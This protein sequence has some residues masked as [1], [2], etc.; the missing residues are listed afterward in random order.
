MKGTALIIAFV[1]MGV[2][3]LL[4]VYF[5][6]FTLTESR[7]AKSQ[8]IG[9]QTYYLAEAGINK[10]IWKLKNE[11]P[12]KTC[13]VTS[14]EAY[15][16]DCSNWSASTI[17]NTDFLIPNS[18]T[19]VAIQ[20][21]ECAKGLITATS[22]IDLGGGK[23]SQ[24]VVKTTVYKA[25]ASPVNESLY[26][27]TPSGNTR[28]KNTTL[29]V[30]S[31]N[32]F[33]NNNLYIQ[34]SSDVTVEGK[35]L[36]VLLIGV[37]QGSSLTGPAQCAKNVC[38]TTSSCECDDKTIFDQWCEPG[39]CPPLEQDMPGIDFDSNATSSYLNQAKAND[40]SAIRTDGKTNCFFTQSEF[41]D[42]LWNDLINNQ[43]TNFSGVIY[44]DPDINLRG[45]VRVSATGT[46]VAGRNIK[47]GYYRKW[48]RGG[49]TKEGVSRI[50]ITDPGQ[51]IPS[52]LLAK[53]KIN[54]A[55]YF[56]IDPA[57]ET[58]DDLLIQGLIYSQEETTISGIPTIP[59]I[60][61]KS[62]KIEGGIVARKLD[63]DGNEETINIY[64]DIDRIKEGIWGG[65]TP[66]PG[67]PIEYSPI[68]TIEHWE[69]EY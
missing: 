42:L 68:I 52:G 50:R 11:D 14:S 41:E 35:A 54:I 20:N 55:S 22:T 13:F 8:T 51:D 19:S 23:F 5:L 67:E 39:K 27:G 53:S 40:C 69:E 47:V 43:V 28:I 12:W 3:L 38:N 7:V 1:I 26:A 21:S 58:V 45:G 16:C 59:D 56:S 17:I 34:G 62:F 29:N 4:G 37:A 44:V 25:L 6:S 49:V 32:I 24:R 60:P 9:T 33:T 46:L 65:P 61:E 48:T 36:A 64:R 18:T 15:G 10:A 63:F 2:L 31:G 30:Y 66:P 57:K